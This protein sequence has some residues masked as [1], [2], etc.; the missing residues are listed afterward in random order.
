[1]RR[2]FAALALLALVSDASADEFE[3]PDLSTL[4]GSSPYI[5]AAPI[6]TRWSGVYAGGLLG[7][8]SAHVDFS[9]ATRQLYAF[10]LQQLAL[11]SE[12]HASQWTVL[13]TQ[14]TGSSSVGG[15][16]GFNSQWDDV[17]IGFD[18]HY[19]RSNF[20]ASAPA[21]P[22]GRRTS[23]GSNVYDI[24]LNGSADMA[25]HDWG[26]ARMRAGYVWNNIMPYATFGI[27][28]GR[29]DLARTATADGE[30]NPATP[31]AICATTPTCVAFSYSASESKKNAWIFGWAAGVGA[32]FLILPNLFLRAEYEYASFANVMG[33]NASINTVRVGAALKY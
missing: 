33:M 20:A 15:F 12:Q 32:D 3:L 22:I 26:A 27:A 17:V 18:V 19:S 1:M 28:F 7:F 2:L 4:R 31:P 10:M 8:G 13:G 25:I 5:P 14:D 21:T 29:A 6:Y 9:G 23:A 16:A 24:V 11:E 30:Q